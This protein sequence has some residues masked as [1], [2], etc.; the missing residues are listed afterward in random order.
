MPVIKRYPNRKLYDTEAKQYISLEGVADL[1]RQGAEVQVVDHAT[2]EDLTALVLVQVIV[3][4]ERARSGFL[5]LPVLTG[6]VQAGGH[7]LTALR[8]NLAVPLDLL[9]G[10]D[11]EIERRVHQLIDLG[12]LAEEEGWL[13]YQKLTSPRVAAPLS[14]D[15]RLERRLRDLPTRQDVRAL[16]DLLDQLSVEV[17][18]LAGQKPADSA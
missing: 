16:T 9:R 1:V 13:I 18:R 12:E 14:P 11:E 5:P 17:E 3:E 4:Q 15:D 6:L 8:R 2:G 10:V 7:T